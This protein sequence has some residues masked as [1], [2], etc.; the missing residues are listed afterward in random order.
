MIKLNYELE[1]EGKIP[2]IFLHGLGG[3][4]K[5]YAPL[6]SL[7][8]KNFKIL[9]LD[10]RGFGASDKPLSPLYSTELWARDLDELMVFLKI[11]QG[12]IAGHSMGARIAAHYASL[13]PHKTLGLIALNMTHWGS[14]PQAKPKLLEVVTQVESQGM[15]SSL[16]LIPPFTDPKLDAFVK[17]EWLENDPQAF[18]LALKSVA[19]DYAEEKPSSFLSKI[20]CPTLIILGDRDTAP[21]QGAEAFKNSLSEA[22]LEVISDCGHYSLLEK[23]AVVKKFILETF[24]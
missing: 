5:D 20:R 10:L 6:T 12:I 18:A 7:L 9:R 2:L 22:K 19:K 14:N 17:K 1:G 13:F 8:R 11:K 4:L 3:T 16:S 24:V 21:L 23:P 15:E